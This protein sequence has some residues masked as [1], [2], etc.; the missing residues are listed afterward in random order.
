[1]KADNYGRRTWDRE[2][3]EKAAK[4]RQTAE[5]AARKA[6]EKKDKAPFDLY[7]PKPGSSKHAEDD[8]GGGD[9][10]RSESDSDRDSDGG[11]FDDWDFSGRDHR[12]RDS[13]GPPV[14]RAL[15][16]RREYKVDLESKLGKS[17]VITKNSPMSNT[18][19]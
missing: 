15:L 19:G 5:K 7:A 6:A 14:K 18:G 9:G 16:Q 17:V 11:G 8:G 10:G 13:A 3:Y 1:M 4:A 2:E 12:E